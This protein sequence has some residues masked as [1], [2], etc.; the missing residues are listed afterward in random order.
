MN[1]C[2]FKLPMEFNEEGMLV[3]AEGGRVRLTKENKQYFK[4]AVNCHEALVKAC[5]KSIDRLNADVSD[6]EVE[7]LPVCDV[8]RLLH[9]M[10]HAREILEAALS[11]TGLAA[12]QQG[13]EE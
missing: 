5:E 1:E 6:E 7:S 10:C 9:D 12:E 13:K 8:D 11:G 2:P 4:K 3:D